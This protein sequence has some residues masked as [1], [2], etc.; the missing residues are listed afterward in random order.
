MHPDNLTDT[1]EY[2]VD[3]NIACYNHEKYIAKALDGVLMQKTNF[4]FRIIIGDDCSKDKSAQIIKEYEEKYPDIIKA[5]YHKKNRG[6]NNGGESN[7]LFLL[8]QSTAKYIALLDGDD[9]WVDENK[10]QKQVDILEK[11]EDTVLCY[12]DISVLDERL[13]QTPMTIFNPPIQNAATT[14]IINSHFVPTASILFRNVIDF[15]KYD[16]MIK[17]IISV[18]IFMELLLSLHG[19]F[20]HINK[21]MAV[22]RLQDSSFTSNIRHDFS[23][24]KSRLFLCKCFNQISGR[25]FEKELTKKMVS[26]LKLELKYI[27]MVEKGE[28][29][30]KQLKQNKK[31]AFESLPRLNALY[32]YMQTFTFNPEKHPG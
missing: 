14:D 16:A 19:T 5:F 18:D 29:Q 7:G 25:K 32:Y 24:V 9:Y 10:L 27:L 11:N 4:K 2:T 30:K 1:K 28:E 6:L 22:Y 23:W 15:N 21:E 3:V 13:V 17:K 26:L 31:N 8:K 20:Y 12:H